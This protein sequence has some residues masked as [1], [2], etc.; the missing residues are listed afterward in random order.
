MKDLL[1]CYYYY[2]FNLCS[3]CDFDQ[4]MYYKFYECIKTEISLKFKKLK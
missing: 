3:L 2:Y 1:K 4:E